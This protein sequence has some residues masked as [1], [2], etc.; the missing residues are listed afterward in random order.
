MKN[1]LAIRKPP[2]KISEPGVLVLFGELFEKGYGNGL[3]EE[4]ISQNFKVIQSTV[5]RR[6]GSSLR[7][8]STDE[9]ATK[10]K[11]PLINTPLEAGFDLE[12]DASGT[13]LVDRLKDVKLNDWQNFSISESEINTFLEKG[14]LR[15]AAAVKAYLK[16]LEQHLEGTTG[17]V[18]F[19]HL[20]AGGVPRAKIIMPLMN[21]VFKGVDERHLS[22]KIF[23]ESDIG[24]ICQKSFL[25]VSAETFRTL[26]IASSALR[27]RL[28]SQNRE[29]IYLAYS[30]HG[31]E[32]YFNKAFQWQSYA[33]YLQG[34][35]K[36]EL[37]QISREYSLQGL[38]T[39]VYNCPEILTNSSSIFKGVEVPL[40]PLITALDQTC[41]K[42]SA[43]VQFRNNLV[44]FLNSENGFA[45]AQE[46]A[47]H[48][49]ADPEVQ[50]TMDYNQWPSHNNGPQMKL[51]LETSEQII[52]LHRDEKKLMTLPLSE[53]VF[54]AC[55]QVMLSKPTHAVAWINHD[56]I[57]E[58][59]SQWNQFPKI[60]N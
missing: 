19:A 25:E 55:G 5:G 32:I 56:V 4:A 17:P 8:L 11:L 9:I 33:P 53:I 41:F 1:Y 46:L 58:L 48:F 47:E 52:G 20:M 16:E 36:M 44:Q 59:A 23:W 13:S 54:K 30:Y 34:Y 15:F 22:S 6:D 18:F 60:E 38:Q 35:A 43:Y 24:K 50:R 51:L 2:Q 28:Q 27:A 39:A 40:Y 21:R 12:T 37:E 45:K 3:V 10:L 42:N 31:T 49:L 7:G 57:A 26:I 29:V 14:R